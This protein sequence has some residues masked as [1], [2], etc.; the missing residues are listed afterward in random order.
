M[1]KIRIENLNDFIYERRQ[2]IEKYIRKIK[3]LI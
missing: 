3:R 2:D 1:R